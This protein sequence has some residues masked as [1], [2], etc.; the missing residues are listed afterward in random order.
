MQSLA[1]K[2]ACRQRRLAARGPAP[3]HGEVQ[4]QAN[5]V[6]LAVPA[7]FAMVLGTGQTCSGGGFT[8]S[9][10]AL[11]PVSTARRLRAFTYAEPAASNLDF[12]PSW[13][14][15][16]HAEHSRGGCHGNCAGN[17]DPCHLGAVGGD[18]PRLL[19]NRAGLTGR[20]EHE[21]W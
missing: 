13:N 6:S 2:T 11:L 7:A 3:W 16:L 5:R 21:E 1:C 19:A 9:R 15:A 10:R 18:E 8:W 4:S 14:G 12:G 17:N 20:E